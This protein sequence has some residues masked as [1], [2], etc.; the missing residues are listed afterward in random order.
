MAAPQSTE[1]D[2]KKWLKI[3]SDGEKS[4][5][6]A[7]EYCNAK[8]INPK[9]YSA[10]KK[11]LREMGHKLPE[12]GAAKSA[13][14]KSPAKKAAP[15]KAVGKSAS[16]VPAVPPNFGNQPVETTVEVETLTIFATLPN[17]IGMQ[18]K[19]PTKEDLDTAFDTLL[20]K[21]LDV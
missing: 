14:K 19:C 16:K 18:I 1:E 13:A 2:I 12:S 3:I 8:D 9:T 7:K 11:R 17:G 5:K 4:G 21:L 6:S 20:Q 10:W 15:K